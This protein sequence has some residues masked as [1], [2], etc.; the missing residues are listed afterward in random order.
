MYTC[1]QDCRRSAGI[2]Q[3][4]F[5]DRTDVYI[6]HSEHR[7]CSP[8]SPYNDLHVQS[9]QTSPRRSST[10][11]TGRYSCT[12]NHIETIIMIYLPPSIDRVMTKNLC[13]LAVL[14]SAKPHHYRT[15]FSVH[16]AAFAQNAGTKWP[17]ICWCAFKKLLTHPRHLQLVNQS[18][19]Q[20]ISTVQCPL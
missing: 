9:A 4:I 1:R 18:I 16:I 15:L 11:S 3:S 7:Q 19:N 2:V 17:F 14:L 5:V 13:R 10:G 12:L 6:A 20:S 8:D